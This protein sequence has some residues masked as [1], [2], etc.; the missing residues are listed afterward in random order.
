M[1]KASRELCI[2]QPSLSEQ[3]KKLEEELEVSLFTRKNRQLQ[4]TV[5]GSTLVGE[6]YEL[7]EKEN[8]L[9]ET[10]RTANKI[11]ERKLTIYYVPGIFLEKL[12][13]LVLQFRRIYPEIM[14]ELKEE[15]WNELN[16]RMTKGEY[17]VIFYLR[18]GDYDIPGTKHLDLATEAT[19]VC[20]S[21]QHP[22]ASYKELCFEDLRYETFCL[23]IM[24]WKGNWYANSLYGIFEAHQAGSPNVM[25]ARTM[26][27]MLLNVRSGI[28]IT[29]L[30]PSF[31]E[32]MPQDL[33]TVPFPELGESTYSLY[34]N[35]YNNNPMVTLFADFVRHHF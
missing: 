25:A 3:I 8:E 26:V 32:Q 34:W 2:S 5:A 12:S 18:L 21:V 6:C 14:V 16:E 9:I 11:S 17:D 13:A 1:T 20:M 10:V 35:R 4:L 31:L 33:C 29:V 7:F 24:P 23:D 27:N 19:K 28:G 15:T 22:L 30:T